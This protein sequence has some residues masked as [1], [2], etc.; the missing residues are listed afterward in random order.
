MERA[1][2]SFFSSAMGWYPLRQLGKISYGFYLWHL[3]IILWMTAPEAFGFAERRMVNLVQFGLT[4][5][6]ATASYRIVE[7]PI[8]Q[9]TIRLGRLRP[10]Y[11]VAVGLGALVVAG[12]V[13]A[14]LLLPDSGDLA[15][16]A[17]ADRSFEACRDEPVPCVKV[18]SDGEGS[19]TIVL[20][21]DSTAQS[22]DPALKVLAGQNGLEYIQAAMGGCPIGHRLIATGSDGELHKASNFDCYDNL[23]P[24]YETIVEEYEPDLIVATSWN[25]TNQHVVDGELQRKGTDE[26]LAVTEAKLQETLDYLTSKGAVVVLIDVLPPGYGVEC[27]E[28]GQSTSEA[29][30]RPVTDKSGEAPYNAIFARLA[31]ESGGRIVSISMQDLVCPNL[32]CPLIIK[33]TV[34]RYDGTHFTATASRD[35]APLLDRKLIDAG[36]YLSGLR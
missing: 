23:P 8:R 1:P 22:Y 30:I 31:D 13:S 35:I 18:E 17:I 33:D 25:E 5:A 19:P 3:P 20:I 4:V 14:V 6:I 7:N 36:V 10:S 12:S 34:L 21:G 26:H 15:A 24:V 29:C 28:H 2:Q 32:E 9:G 16:A 27:L 11:T